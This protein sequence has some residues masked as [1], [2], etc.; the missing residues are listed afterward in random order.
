MLDGSY[1]PSS[2]DSVSTVLQNYSET[3]T[4]T[5]GSEADSAVTHTGSS[6]SSGTVGVESSRY[7]FTSDT[8]PSSVDSVSTVPH[9][10]S[11]TTTTTKGSEGDSTVTN[12]G[13]SLS[14]G[15]EY[16]HTSDN[17]PPSVDSVST[18][19][20]NYSGTNTTTNGS[21][22]NSA[23]TYTVSSL[24][25]GS[26]YTLTN[27]STPPSVY[28][29]STVLQNYNGTNTKTNGSNGDSAV[30]HTF[31][32][33]SPGTEHTL[34]SGSTSS[35]VNS[36]SVKNRTNTTLTLEWNK[37]NNSS[38]YSYRLN[39][40]GRNST[41][42]GSV[43]G[44]VVTHTVS[45]LSPGT[46]YTF[47]LYTVLEGVESSGYTFTSVTTPSNVNSVS[48]KNRT[49]TTLTLEWNKVNNS[50]SY[51][52]R[53]NYNGI[54]NTINGS[55]GGSVV[56][57]T[58]SSLSPGTK[59]T[60]TLY[61]VFEGVESSGYT[62]TSVTT[63]AS[64][65]SVSVKSRTET[66]LTLQWNKVNNSS[67][68]SYRLNYNGIN[69]T[70]NG[71]VGGSVVTHTVSSLSPG[72]KYTFT[73][74]TVFEGVES[75]GYTFTSVTTPASVDSVSVKSRTYT[76]LTVQWN[77]VN[78]SSSYSYRLNY[79]GINNT[80]NGSVGGSVVT[81]TVSSLSPGT[82]YTFTLYTVFEG[83]ESS[84]YNF[85]SVTTPSNV[86]SVSVKS[87]TETELILEWNKVNSS[88]S[89]SYRLNY[90]DRNNTINGSVGGSVLTLTVS[91]LSPGTK[92][93]FT[94]YTVFEGVES[95]GYTFTSVTTPSSVNSVSV[96]SR[97]ESELK[98]EWNKVNNSSSY[99]YRLNYNGINN[100]ISGSEG[101]SVVTLTVSS[102]SPG[103]KYT[104]TLY[105]VIEDVESS[106]YTFTSVTT[107]SSVDSVSVKN[108]TETELTLQ[109]NKVN[110]SSS[111][112][113]RLNYNGINNTINGSVGGSV[114]TLT[115][116]SLSPGTKY[117][118]T[119]YTVFEGVES[120][121]YTF[122]SKT[123]P[124][125]V[126]SVSV[127]SRNETE[128]KLEWDKVNNSSSYS[129]RLN[130]NGINNTINGSVGGPVVTLTVSSLSPGTKY[131]FTLY[132]VFEDV[133]SSEYNFTSVTIPA[134]V[135]GLHCQY[136]SDG[137]SLTLL[138]SPPSGQ[139]TTVQVNVNGQSFNE[140]GESL[141]IGG[142][143]PA[144]WYTL[145]V[146]ALCSDTQSN[147]ASITCQTAPGRIIAG[148]VVFLLLVIIILCIGFYTWRRKP[149]LLS[150]FKS[151]SS[152]ETQLPNDKYKPIPQ[153]QFPKHF[154][155]MSRNGNRGF[156]KEYEELQ[157]AGTDQSCRTAVLPMNESKNRFS[158]VLAYDSSRVK[159]SVHSSADSDYINANYMPG[160][161]RNIQQYIAAQGPLASMVCDFWRMVWEQKC[162]AIVMLTSCTES[163]RIKCDQ[164]WPVDSSPCAYGNL[165]VTV[166]SEQIKKS[167]TLREFVVKNTVNSEERRVS[168]FHFTAWPHHGVP[169]RTD[170]LIQFQ[171]AVRQH[172][173]SSP[174]TGPTVVHCSAGV[175]RTGIFIAL[176]TVLQQLE[177]E[178]AV[179]IAA[180]VHRM[181]LNRPL[182]VQTEA[183]YVF[184]H[185]CIVDSLQPR[186]NLIPEAVY[187]NQDI[188]EDP[189]VHD[190]SDVYVI[191]DIYV[192]PDAN[193]NQDIYENPDNA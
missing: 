31:V 48:V 42:N 54:N 165:Q 139:R 108:H 79:N 73:L 157:V 63:P 144:Q 9:N 1:A 115:V 29:V 133:E 44:S 185:Q 43:G 191:P 162:Q 57:L 127:K 40:N 76:T 186:N 178:R 7:T 153:K 190:N 94:L 148:I 12:T 158:N 171:R 49:N 66:N 59:Y 33:L 163:A 41:I 193:E 58:V 137:Y 183:Q 90:N 77:K 138:W 177:K 84:G 107:P 2:V 89:Y 47:T 53:L 13:L 22:G 16:T 103:T 78:N 147:P 112:S 3:T 64:V 45:S 81:L 25:P 174:F 80:I 114:V 179:S 187:D 99:S 136:V 124:S 146:T 6:L 74:Y 113:Y 10:Y 98:L 52:Y 50:S 125:S 60:F 8:T 167:W 119:L 129:Y 28:S 116:S 85:T 152:T 102:L 71:S 168:H 169:R 159:L 128:L 176:D 18:V 83:V 180:C 109:W 88:S 86:N 154:N 82:K 96:K 69:N 173:E 184:L 170:E 37:V 106:G 92:Y 36:V 5:S 46:K 62:F 141:S 111:Y 75:S 87:R 189:D 19:L 70:I 35:N 143:Q 132:T 27:D 118:F 131:T 24:S 172:I 101:G 175:D 155:S 56:T 34:T 39:Y 72:T 68:Y 166:K 26:E 161:G 51:S 55:E 93:T 140:S 97:T 123:T 100:N 156:R 181:R 130:Y 117:T 17:T 104:F 135:T 121:G 151:K 160:Y 67:S 38:S 164:Y 15:T 120:S 105:T 32:S 182:M 134:A 142:L 30:T 95:S 145:T 20:Q 14:P 4:T 192:T 11:G 61:T 21:N 149:E 150:I 110:N 122:T 91:S 65:N 126:N 23:V 188:Y